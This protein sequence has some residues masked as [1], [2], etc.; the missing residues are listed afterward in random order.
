MIV[1][2]V[3]AWELDLQGKATWG[4]KLGW[5]VAAKLYLVGGALWHDHRLY[6]NNFTIETEPHNWRKRW[7]T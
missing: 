4:N 2:S 1:Y 3:N 6:T 5:L 7:S